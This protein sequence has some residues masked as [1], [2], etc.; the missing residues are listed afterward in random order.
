MAHTDI[1]SLDD[2]TEHNKGRLGLI[3]WH[4]VARIEDAGEGE[5]AI[6]PDVATSVGVVDYDVRVAGGRKGGVVAGEKAS[7]LQRRILSAVPVA[8]DIS[9]AVYERDTNTAGQQVGK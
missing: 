8:D 9:I 5:V 6:L 7:Q 3:V 2:A 4:E 1:V